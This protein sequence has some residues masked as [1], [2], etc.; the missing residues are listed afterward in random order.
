MQHSHSEGSDL[1]GSNTAEA[2]DDTDPSNE[3]ED[4][5]CWVTVIGVS[6]A[7]VR[8][9]VLVTSETGYKVDNRSTR[10]KGGIFQFYCLFYGQ[11]Q[12]INLNV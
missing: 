4:R 3:A 8:G 6:V 7:G 1:T 2:E 9:E 10:A 5:S 11:F 12:S